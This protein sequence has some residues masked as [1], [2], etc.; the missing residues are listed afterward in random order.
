MAY[1]LLDVPLEKQ[2]SSNTCWHAAA[3]MIWYYWQKVTGKQ[4]PM[5]TFAD[6][7]AQNKTI[8]DW[9]GLAKKVGLKEV[10][11]SAS[12]TGDILKQMLTDH[13]PIW[14]AGTWYGP[15]HVVVLTGIDG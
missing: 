6:A 1:L 2:T 10:T 5:N 14:C 13:G 9:T 8:T 15:G 11:R 12:Y 7:W 3:L 4:G